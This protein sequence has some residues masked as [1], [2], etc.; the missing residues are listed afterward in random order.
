MYTTLPED[1]KKLKTFR[2]SHFCKSC[3]IIK[4]IWDIVMHAILRSCADFHFFLS[5]FGLPQS[6][7]ILQG[8]VLKNI[9]Y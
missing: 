3:Q 7:S 8:E 5:R 6:V 1:A 9:G 2:V 4:H